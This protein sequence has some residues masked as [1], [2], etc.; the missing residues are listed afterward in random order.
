MIDAT[1][2]Q[3]HGMITLTEPRLA[4]LEALAKDCARVCGELDTATAEINRLAGRLWSEKQRT[5][6]MAAKVARLEA[7]L[8]PR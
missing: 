1:K 5:K 7:R 6:L 4:E 3:W 2:L 8:L